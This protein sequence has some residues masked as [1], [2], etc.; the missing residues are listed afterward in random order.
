MGREQL[1]EAVDFELLLLGQVDLQKTNKGIQ[2][3]SETL[4]TN[5]RGNIWTNTYLNEELADI[6]ALV[7]LKLDHFTILWVLN[8][9]PIAGKFLW[10][11]KR[12]NQQKRCSSNN[13]NHLRTQNKAALWLY[14]L[15]GLD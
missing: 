4:K 11:Q 1:L 15:E 2:L 12:V 13:Q 3:H 9:C 10:R 5:I 8:H 6:L 7:S 14:L